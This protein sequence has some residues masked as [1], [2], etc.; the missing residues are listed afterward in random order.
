MLAPLTKLR[1]LKIFLEWYGSME[2]KSPD[3][4]LD[5]ARVFASALGNH[6]RVIAVPSKDDRTWRTF[7][8]DGGDVLE[9]REVPGLR[10]L[11]N[12]EI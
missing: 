2:T 8:V 3:V 10:L 7:I 5:V 4:A 12:Y 9:E 11:H 6:L 1:R